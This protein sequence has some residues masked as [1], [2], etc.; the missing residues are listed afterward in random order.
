MMLVLQRNEFTSVSN[1]RETHEVGHRTRRD[2]RRSR[3]DALR[4]DRPQNQGFR[5]AHKP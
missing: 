3:P 4:R 5:G 1:P 2:P